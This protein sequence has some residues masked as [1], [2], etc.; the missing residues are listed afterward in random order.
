MG[1]LDKLFGKKS[2]INLNET[3]TEIPESWSVLKGNN[4]GN[5]MLIRK[6]DGL[7]QIAGNINYSTSCGIAFKLL[8][9]DEKGLP[10]AESEPELN[11]LEDDIFEIFENDLNSIV[12]TVITTSGFRE[13]V[14]YSKNVDEFNSRLEKLQAKYQKYELTSYNRK[15]EG[16][17]TFKSFK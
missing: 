5:L 12:S 10:N 6:N 1:I 17:E 16:W 3:V 7:N 15:D 2:E 9:P 13:Y 11:D 14:L 4:N 8:R